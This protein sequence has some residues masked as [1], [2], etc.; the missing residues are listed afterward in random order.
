MLSIGFG[1]IAIVI[2]VTYLY[3][4]STITKTP[5]DGVFRITPKHTLFMYWEIKSI[6]SFFILM[7]IY[8]III[9]FFPKPWP[10]WISDWMVQFFLFAG[11]FSLI[12]WFVTGEEPQEIEKVHE[13][14]LTIQETRHY[15]LWNVKVV[16]TEGEHRLMWPFGAVIT[17][18][19]KQTCNPPRITV[20]TGS[21][22]KLF[23]DPIIKFFIIDNEKYLQDGQVIESLGEKAMQIITSEVADIR[24]QLTQQ[25]S[26]IQTPTQGNSD[27]KLEQEIKASEL[28][29]I[30]IT[31]MHKTIQANV[32][33]DIKALSSTEPWGINIVEVTLPEFIPNEETL[34]AAAK[35][36][37]EKLEAAAEGIEARSLG[38]VLRHIKGVLPDVPQK[39][40]LD[41]GLMQKKLL[42]V[43]QTKNTEEKRY[44][45]EV[46][47][48]LIPALV[49]IVRILKG[50][51][52]NG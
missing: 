40:I 46:F 28:E 19:G 18:K 35:I 47:E 7:V 30:I 10:K 26:A 2:V 5:A 3:V 51:V 48:K 8:G 44:T 29:M 17:P 36:L 23:I 24:N 15:R 33:R 38:N 43:T 6:I 41:A 13:G 52:S 50:G 45:S 31:S 32:V 37:K 16:L 25:Q 11:I 22:I 49:E 27:D 42:T 21:G 20:I 9:H 34:A 39:D 4:K 1:L 12:L 14:T